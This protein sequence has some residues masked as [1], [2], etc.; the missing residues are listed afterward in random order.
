MLNCASVS[1]GLFRS[2]ATL[3]GPHVALCVW[4][5]VSLTAPLLAQLQMEDAVV[6]S[7]HPPQHWDRKSL[8]KLFRSVCQLLSKALF[9]SPVQ[10]SS[11]PWTFPPPPP[12]RILP[13]SRTA[14]VCRYHGWDW[15]GKK[16]PKKTDPI[17]APFS[18]N[19]NERLSDS[20]VAC[21][22]ALSMRF[23]IYALIKSKRK[24]FIAPAPVEF[25][26]I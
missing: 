14:G 11:E 16:N 7:H 1:A 22:I 18:V 19:L 12:L 25:F 20:P 3:G 6:S 13:I 2:A 10:K 21:I 23:N 9:P 5:C 24:N 15:R 26:K 4:A 17:A 8:I